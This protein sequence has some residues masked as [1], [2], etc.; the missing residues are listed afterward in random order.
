MR[1]YEL[2]PPLPCVPPSRKKRR[3]LSTTVSDKS[4]KIGLTSMSA[5]IFIYF[6]REALH[7]GSFRLSSWEVRP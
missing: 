5:L 7:G 3:G 1:R 4:K 2:I 6:L